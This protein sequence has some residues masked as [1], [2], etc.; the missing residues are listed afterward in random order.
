[1]SGKQSADESSV[2]FQRTAFHLPADR[3][4]PVEYDNFNVVTRTGFNGISKRPYVSIVPCSYILDVVDE[5]IHALQLGSSWRSS[6]PVKTVHLHACLRIDVVGISVARLLIASQAVL[7]REK[8][9]EGD[10]VGL[11]L[12]EDAV[13]ERLHL[14]IDR[15][16]IGQHSY[17]LAFDLLQQLAQLRINHLLPQRSSAGTRD[18]DSNYNYSQNLHINIIKTTHLS[19]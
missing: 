4:R 12:R 2:H 13:E 9:L 6:H 19:H 10:V 5:V 8:T 14:A 11:S 15:S 3:I 17:S 16:G 1:M 7:R 18:K